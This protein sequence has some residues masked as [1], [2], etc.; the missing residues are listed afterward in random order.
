MV[1][2]RILEILEEQNHTKYW[3]FKQMDL[4][5]QNFNRMVM[6]ETRSIR[7]ENLDILSDIL[8]ENLN[9]IEPI[10]KNWTDVPEIY[11]DT[12]VFY[13]PS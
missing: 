4:S 1:R 9:K 3:L 8:N 10:K 7:F 11:P 2:L 6:N 13:I 5:Y 12:S